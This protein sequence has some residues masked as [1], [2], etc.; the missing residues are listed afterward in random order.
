MK[1]DFKIKEAEADQRFSRVSADFQKTIS[2]FF[3]FD[4]I[5]FL[6]SAKSLKRSYFE[7][8]FCDGQ[9]SKK[10]SNKGRFWKTLVKT[11]R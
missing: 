10:T 5:D 4:H 2:I 1:I 11:L 3:E 8:F 6:S 7:Q 9:A